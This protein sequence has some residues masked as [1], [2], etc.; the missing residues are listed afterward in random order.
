[1]NLQELEEQTGL[2]ARLIR[3]L[4]SQEVVPRPTGGKRFAAYG[5]DHLRALA[6]YNAAKSE[7]IESLDVIRAK[8]KAGDRIQVVTVVDGVELRIENGK[9]KD[10]TAFVEAVRKLAS[11]Q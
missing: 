1:M 2:P 9:L 7:G 8:I 11:Q 6:V 3:F 4:I 10:V 5:D